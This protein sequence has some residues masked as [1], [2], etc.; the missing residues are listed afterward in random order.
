MDTE[1]GVFPSAHLLDHLFRGTALC[2][3]KC[4]DLILLTLCFLASFAVKWG[5]IRSQ[6]WFSTVFLCLVG[7]FVV[8]MASL[9]LD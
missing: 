3:Q 5:G 1:P 9:F 6:I 4:E 7:D 8:I 2:Q